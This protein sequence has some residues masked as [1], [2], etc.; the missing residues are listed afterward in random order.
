MKRTLLFAALISCIG[1]VQ[2]QDCFTELPDHKKP[3]SEEWEG[4]KGIHAAWGTSD[5]RYSWHSLP[6]LRELKHAETLCA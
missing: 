2:A 6:N 1:L 3:C 4:V 5:V